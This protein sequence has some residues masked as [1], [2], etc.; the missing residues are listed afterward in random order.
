MHQLDTA[1]QQLVNAVAHDGVGLAAT[2][3]HQHPGPG[4]TLDE[5][6][7][8]RPG[9]CDGRGIRQDISY[10]TAETQRELP[11]QTLT[12]GEQ[13]I[14]DKDH[15]TDVSQ[16]NRELEPGRVCQPEL[17][18]STGAVSG[19]ESGRDLGHGTDEITLPLAA[20]PLPARPS[21]PEAGRCARLR[22]RPPGLWRSPHG[23]SHSRPRQ[24]RGQS[25]ATPGARSRRT[26]RGPHATHRVSWIS[27]IFPGIARHTADSPA[28]Q[29]N[30]GSSPR[31]VT[32]D[33]P[34]G[35][36]GHTSGRIEIVQWANLM[37]ATGP[38]NLVRGRNGK[39]PHRRLWQPSAL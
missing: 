25:S 28:S 30:I 8:P 2:D 37:V 6:Q 34:E 11:R 7:P 36:E 38:T 10:R 27:R 9:Q 21:L 23:P 20:I 14:G 35:D 39:D 5:S 31:S 22:P 4:R 16:N 15:S 12:S 18:A 17:R 32:S 33:T 13:P 3:L 26:A 1:R 29:Y 19:A 24:P